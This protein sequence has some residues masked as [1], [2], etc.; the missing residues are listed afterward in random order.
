MAVEPAAGDLKG[1]TASPPARFIWRLAQGGALPDTS[2][3]DDHWL[4]GRTQRLDLPL[5]LREGAKAQIRAVV[6]VDRVT[7]WA[8]GSQIGQAEAPDSAH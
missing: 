2:G 3:R 4:N 7:G 8:L 1:L 6:F 5:D